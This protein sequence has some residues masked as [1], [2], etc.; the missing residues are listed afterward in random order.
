[1][2]VQDFIRDLQ[3]AAGENGSQ[4]EV[5]FRSSWDKIDDLE[6]DVIDSDHPKK[7]TVWLS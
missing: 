4:K 5:L 2:T 6:L 1:M 7:V 3:Q